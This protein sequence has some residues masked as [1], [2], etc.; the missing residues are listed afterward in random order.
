MKPQASPEYD[1]SNPL[2]AAQAADAEYETCRF[3]AFD[4]S[5]L[6]G[7]IEYKT[8]KL[9]ASKIVRSVRAG[10]KAKLRCASHRDTVPAATAFQRPKGAIRGLRQG[11]ALARAGRKAKLRCGSHR[12]TVPA[13]TAFQRPQ[14]ALRVLLTAGARFMS[15]FNLVEKLLKRWKSGGWRNKKPQP[16]GDSRGRGQSFPHKWVEI[17]F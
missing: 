4:L 6:R 11:L 12:D 10:R 15:R 13:A 3:G 5:D 16:P 7:S 8:V 2:G 9:K 17:F 14:G 1:L